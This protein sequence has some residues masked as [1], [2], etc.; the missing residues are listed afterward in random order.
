MAA[1]L[2]R[3]IHV[4]SGGIYQGRSQ[5]S[6]YFTYIVTPDRIRASDTSIPQCSSQLVG[7]F[8][9]G[10]QTKPCVSLSIEKQ[11]ST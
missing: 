10:G 2:G 8:F 1:Q 11:F 3:D 9:T 4:R 5:I 7:I 6:V